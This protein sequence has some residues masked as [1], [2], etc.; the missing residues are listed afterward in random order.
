MYKL[1]SLLFFMWLSFVAT[2]QQKDYIYYNQQIQKAEN[3]IV[4]SSYKK[5]VK[6]YKKLYKTYPKTFAK[7]DYNAFV[8]SILANKQNLSEVFLLKL[9]KKGIYLDTILNKTKK[10]PLFMSYYS[11][12][13]W[14]KIKTNYFAL[15]QTYLTHRRQGLIDTLKQLAYRDQHLRQN[16]GYRVYRDT[17]AKVD[18]ENYEILKAIILQNGFP[19]EE[20]I[21]TVNFL[22]PNYVPLILRHDGQSAKDTSILGSVLYNEVLKGNFSAD[23]YA[24]L[25]DLPYLR[26]N[27]K[28]KY[29]ASFAIVV[30]NGKAAFYNNAEEFINKNKEEEFINKNRENLGLCTIEGQKQKAIFLTKNNLFIFYIDPPMLFLE[31][32]NDEKM[33]T[34]LEERFKTKFT[35]I[36]KT[37]LG[38]S[39]IIKYDIK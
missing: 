20:I 28:T 14:E 1:F 29:N 25:E 19:T 36:D 37:K 24:D 26:K 27:R 15:Y 12:N 33:R 35:V 38:Q 39:F 22:R 30:C 18:N 10:E 17:I 21:S 8:V 32:I 9:A 16:G 34:E 11:T 13:K 4:S 5:A 3:Y 2:A 7:D 6:V 23:Y 31:G